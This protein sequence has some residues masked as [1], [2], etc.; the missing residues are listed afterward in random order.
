MTSLSLISS[1]RPHILI[2]PHWGLRL[3]HMILGVGGAYSSV[4]STVLSGVTTV[5]NS[6]SVHP[7]G[8]Y[9]E[10]CRTLT[11]VLWETCLHCC[12]GEAWPATAWCWLLPGPHDRP[13][14]PGSRETNDLAHIQSLEF[15]P[16]SGTFFLHL[17][18]GEWRE[19]P[20]FSPMKMALP[21]PTRRLCSD[22]SW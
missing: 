16:R 11:R 18:H 17:S 13:L 10:K 6:V 4:H 21:M 2:P 22:G 14:V 3:Q 5:A 20:C 1:Q 15:R 8:S 9:N 19:W 12:V 7:L